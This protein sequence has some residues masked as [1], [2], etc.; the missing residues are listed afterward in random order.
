MD[1]HLTRHGGPFDRGGAD[2]YYGRS[3]DPHLYIFGS[4]TA[5]RIG[6][7]DMSLEEINEYLEGYAQAEAR[8]DQKD[9][10]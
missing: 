9:W 5:E 6:I 7:D 4:Y 10:G 2:Y 1:K 8:G 3:I